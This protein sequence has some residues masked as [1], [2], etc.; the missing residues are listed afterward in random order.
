M[1]IGAVGN[2]SVFGCRDSVLHCRGRWTVD[3]GLLEEH[4][5]EMQLVRIVVATI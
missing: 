3:R 5:D 1:A 4:F 2:G